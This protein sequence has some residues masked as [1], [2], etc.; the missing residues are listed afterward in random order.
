MSNYYQAYPNET[1]KGRITFIPT[2]YLDQ[3]KHQIILKAFD[4]AGNERTATVDFT[5]VSR[6]KQNQLTV[7]KILGW[8]NPFQDQVKIGFFHNRSGRNILKDSLLY[9]I[10]RAACTQPSVWNRQ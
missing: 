8:P 9:A 4:V 2:L 7:S 3:G 1:G 5:V 10:H 6:W